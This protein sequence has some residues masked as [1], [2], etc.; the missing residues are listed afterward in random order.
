MFAFRQRGAET[1]SRRDAEL[2]EDLAEMPLDGAGADEQL[3]ADLG[4]RETVSCEPR[5]LLLLRRSARSRVSAL[6]FR[7]FSRSQPARDARVRRR[8]PSRSRRTCRGRSAAARAPRRAGPR[9]AAIRR[10]AGARERARSGAVCGEPFDRLAVQRVGDLALRPA[11][12]GSAPRCRAPSR[13]RRR[14]VASDSRSR[15]ARATSVLAPCVLRPRRAPAAPTLR[16]Q[17]DVFRRLPRG[18][19]AASSYRASPLYRTAAA[20]CANRTASPGP[21]LSPPRS[22]PRSARRLRPRPRAA[23]RAASRERR[24]P[25]AGRLG[26]RVG[27]GDR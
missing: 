26:D 20:Q 25:A 24:E 4:V 1:A 21:P 22:W 12:P 14:G 9:A 10:R 17:I 5:D 11:A 23:R 3:R 2:G 13:C 15:H 19:E 7:T 8:P 6:R 16:E 27:L 18:R